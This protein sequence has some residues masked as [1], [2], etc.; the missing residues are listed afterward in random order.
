MKNLLISLLCVTLLCC[1]LIVGAQSSD[2][3]PVP[4]KVYNF[5][6]QQIPEIYRGIRRFNVIY[7]YGEQTETHNFNV[8]IQQFLQRYDRNAYS[9]AENYRFLREHQSDFGSNLNEVPY[10]DIYLSIWRSK[11]IEIHSESALRSYTDYGVNFLLQNGIA[12]FGVCM[13]FVTMLMQE[14]LDYHY[15]ADR[16]RIAGG[17]S[18]GIVD[19]VEILNTFRSQDQNAVAGVCRDVHD[20]GARMLKQICSSYYSQKYPKKK[21][22]FDRYIF[23]QSWATQASQHM[24]IS[25]IDPVD[26]KKIYE[27]D[28]GRLTEKQNS[29]GYDHGRNYGNAYRIWKFD[30]KSQYMKAIDSRRTALGNLLDDYLYNEQDFDSFTGIKSI[31]PYSSADIKR[32]FNSGINLNFALGTMVQNQKFALTSLLYRTKKKRMPG[33]LDFSCQFSLQTLIM[34]ELEKKNL[35]YPNYNFTTAVVCYE[36]PRIIVSLNTKAVQISKKVT[37]SLYTDNSVESLIYQDF[38]EATD[39]KKYN[40]AKQSADG[41]IMLTQGLKLQFKKEKVG[42]DAELR[43]QN[44]GFLAAKEVRLMSGNFGSL[45]SNAVM[46]SPAQDIIL[47]WNYRG[48]SRMKLSGK[49][50]LERTNQNNVQIYQQINFSGKIRKVGYLQLEAGMTR[51]LSGFAYFWYPVDRSWLGVAFMNKAKNTRIGLSVRQF[52]DKE[53]AGSFQTSFFW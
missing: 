28:W 13:R 35:M 45:I 15:D 4:T 53:V 49:S 14:Q 42:L 20:M 16:L 43:V 24:T 39:I 51:M 44:R 12:D 17:H 29:L 40:G 21:I 50:V 6:L 41:A 33:P 5:Q 38:F 37:G 22:D 10:P 26:T 23:V 27:L 46:V 9:L 19:M 34:E 31:E 2:S 25:F 1:S 47:R 7:D 3:L 18:E 36:Y 8:Q 30:P 32:N 52:N 11:M 48:D